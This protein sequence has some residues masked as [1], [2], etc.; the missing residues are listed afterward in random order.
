MKRKR[1]S[2]PAVESI[3]VNTDNLMEV[4][5]IGIDDDPGHSIGPGDEGD[6]GA[7]PGFQDED[8]WPSFSPWSD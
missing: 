7:K 4:W 6:I 3:K 2:A 8:E 5:S 1:Y